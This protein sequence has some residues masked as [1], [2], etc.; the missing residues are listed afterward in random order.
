M[1]GEIFAVDAID[2]GKS[3]FPIDKPALESA[4]WASRRP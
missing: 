1:G 3:V 2:V 4:W